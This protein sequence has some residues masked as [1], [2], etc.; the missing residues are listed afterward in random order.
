[1][2]SWALKFPRWSRLGLEAVVFVMPPS[3]TG[4]SLG[5]YMALSLVDN[6]PFRFKKA[7][8][9]AEVKIFSEPI[10]AKLILILVALTCAHFAPSMASFPRL[11]ATVRTTKITTKANQ[12]PFRN[13]RNYGPHASKRNWVADCSY[14]TPL[15]FEPYHSA[16]QPL[17]MGRPATLM[18][19]GSWHGLTLRC[20]R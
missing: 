17:G 10:R 15:H 2:F 14:S 16:Q 3:T 1:M 13:G 18:A 8:E 4:L 6:L 5:R 7:E 20:A 11:Q 9:V 12:D 19:D